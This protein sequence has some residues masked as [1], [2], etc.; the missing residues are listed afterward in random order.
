M[1]P[2]GMGMSGGGLIWLLLVAALTIVPF[3]RLLP[4]AGLSPWIALVSVVPL[5][6]LV[7]LYVLAFRTWPGDHKGEG[8]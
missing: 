6:A 7:L 4:R 2:Q 8:A 3:F 1:E 5:G